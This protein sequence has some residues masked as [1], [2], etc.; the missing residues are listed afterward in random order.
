MDFFSLAALAVGRLTPTDHSESQARRAFLRRYFRSK[1]T[2]F[3]K[4]TYKICVF[5]PLL[6]T[7]PLPPRFTRI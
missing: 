4:P 3:I 1:Y 2:R 5:E 7:R 6:R